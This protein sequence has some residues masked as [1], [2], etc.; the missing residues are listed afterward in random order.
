LRLNYY[1]DTFDA[2]VL[3]VALP[4]A[5]A[6]PRTAAIVAKIIDEID[7]IMQFIN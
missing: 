1:Y 7:T 3:V 6:M 5:R 2:L 4:P